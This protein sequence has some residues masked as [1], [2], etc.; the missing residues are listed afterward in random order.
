MAAALKPLDMAGDLS[1]E[2]HSRATYERHL[3]DLGFG[4]ARNGMR[5]NFGRGIAIEIHDTLTGCTIR[6]FEL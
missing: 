4:R 6:G 5:I 3:S 2:G 1:A